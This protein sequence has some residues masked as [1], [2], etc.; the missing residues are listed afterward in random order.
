M[1]SA[2]TS[3]QRRAVAPPGLS[4]WV[5]ILDARM[6]ILSSWQPASR[7]SVLV[8]WVALAGVGRFTALAGRVR[9]ANGVDWSGSEGTVALLEVASDSGKRFGGTECR[10]IVHTRTNALA[11]DSIL[12]SDKFQGSRAQPWESVAI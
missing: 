6:P 5:V 4:E 10:V 11:F 3:A 1:A 12:L 7:L 8:T 2:P 9:V